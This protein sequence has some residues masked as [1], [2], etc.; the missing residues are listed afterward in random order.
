MAARCQSYVLC[1]KES[2]GAKD[3]LFATGKGLLETSVQLRQNVLG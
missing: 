3:E 1:I 2:V